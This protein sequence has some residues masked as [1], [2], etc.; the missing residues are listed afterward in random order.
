MIKRI[1][2][3]PFLVTF[4][5]VFPQSQIK[6]QNKSENKEKGLTFGASYIGDQVNN[7]SGG[8]RRGSA[9]LGM[10]NLT[11]DLN[12]EKA[13]LW[14]GGHFFVKA[15]N[16]HGANPSSKLLGDIQV[17]SNIDAG[18]HTYIQEIWFKQTLRNV[19]FTIG[20]QDLNVEFANSENGA[21][22]L[23][24]SF[25]ILPIISGNI[26][27][28]IFPLTT[29]GVTTKWNISERTRW[30][31]A[32]YDGSPTDFDY[33]PYNIKWEFI[34]GDG[35]L[36]ISEFQNDIIVNGKPGTYKIG[37]YAH[38]HIIEDALNRYLPDS[39][40]Q[41]ILGVYLYADQL[42]WQGV[43]RT[44]ALFSQI[45]YSPS[46]A[47]HNDFY[48]GMGINYTGIFAPRRQDQLGLALASMHFSNSQKSET[49]LEL[50]Y[51]YLLTES[52]YL[53][54]D[55]QYIIHPAG[56]DNRPANAFGAILRVGLSF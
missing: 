15:T 9:Y 2:F 39:L 6:A 49:A 27:P 56:T 55:L 12:T 20:L 34:S 28:P 11:L 33:N 4:I 31:N 52:L 41:N 26:T 10:A 29:L 54:P 44:I 45:G 51:Q 53:Q 37:G 16:T 50:T 40:N 43:N 22:Y 8:L 7:L 46:H 35:L 38:S 36:A 32:L 23:N 42:L 24:S 5:M 21:L 47:S 14:S 3:V 30:L 48:I 13:S 19:E 1:N 18:A 17:A 25:G